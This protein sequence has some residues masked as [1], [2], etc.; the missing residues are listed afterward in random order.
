MKRRSFIKNL[1][2]AVAITTVA[3]VTI[4]QVVER[5]KIPNPPSMDKF[6]GDYE[7]EA[8]YIGNI[9][10]VHNQWVNSVWK[11]HKLQNKA[12]QWHT[13]KGIIDSPLK[14]IGI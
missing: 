8:M 14:K 9:T 5:V 6:G 4:V 3:P 2:K 12:M 11:K 7:G 1:V 13:S 10:E